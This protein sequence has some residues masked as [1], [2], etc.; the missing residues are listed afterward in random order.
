MTCEDFESQD[1]GWLVRGA[2]RLALLLTSASFQRCAKLLPRQLRVALAT[3]LSAT[4]NL[5]NS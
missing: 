2:S 3:V 4:A 5:L 1:Q